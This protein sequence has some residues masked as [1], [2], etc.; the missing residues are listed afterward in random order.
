LDGS[1]LSLTAARRLTFFSP[2][3][4]G[5][6]LRQFL[7]VQTGSRQPSGF[8]RAIRIGSCVNGVL[9]HAEADALGTTFMTALHAVFA[10]VSIGRNAPHSPAI[11]FDEGMAEQDIR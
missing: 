9:G 8:R 7:V 6:D 2:R 4:R 1:L 3:D 10:K 11:Q 5:S